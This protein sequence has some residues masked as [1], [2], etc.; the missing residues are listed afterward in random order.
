M[1]PGH[2]NFQRAAEVPHI[3]H[4]AVSQRIRQLEADLWVVLFDRKLRGVALTAKGKSYYGAVEEVLRFLTAGLTQTA[5][6]LTRVFPWTC[7][8]PGNALR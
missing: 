7:R 6:D 3:S 2:G 4:G 1:S 8:P 5:T